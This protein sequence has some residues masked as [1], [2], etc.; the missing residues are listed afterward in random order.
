MRRKTYNY[1]KTYTSPDDLFGLTHRI[2]YFKNLKDELE[3]HQSK[4][5]SALFRRNL[6]EHHRKVNYTNE[7]DRIRGVLEQPSSRLPSQTIETLKAR[8]NKL[9]ELGANITDRIV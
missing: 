9:L 3:A 5:K 4:A 7:L 6:L 2:S 1:S 8:K